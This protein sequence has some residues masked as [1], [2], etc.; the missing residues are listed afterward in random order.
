MN[1]WEHFKKNFIT[2][3][4]LLVFGFGLGKMWNYNEILTDCKVLGMFRVGQVA[5]GC[6]ISGA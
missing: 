2:Y 5:V 4:A 3:M 6:R 1:A